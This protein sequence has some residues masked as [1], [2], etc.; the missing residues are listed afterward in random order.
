MLS[1]NEVLA[2]HS[3]FLDGEMPAVDAELWRTHLANCAQCARYD[4]VLRK[5]LRVLQD[6]RQVQPDPE[7]MLHLR[8]RLA[9]EDQR[10]TTPVTAGAATAV[11]V[12]AVLALAAWLPIMF[13][14][15]ASESQAPLAAGELGRTAS[16]IAWHG[17]SAIHE[18]DSHSEIAGPNVSLN[19]THTAVSVIESGYTPLIIEAPTS[20]P[21]YTRVTLT[22]FNSR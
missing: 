8:Y 4:R 18:P 20:P 21:S 7:F 12:A 3:E 14:S 5:G 11:T 10:M 1:C 9:Y 19:H 17:G 2:R 6:D 16:E 13:F 22:S 15:R